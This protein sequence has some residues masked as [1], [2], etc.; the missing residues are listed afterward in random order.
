MCVVRRKDK[1]D[2]KIGVGIKFQNLA[3]GKNTHMVRVV[4]EKGS[5]LPKHTHPE[6]QTGILLEG[7]MDLYINGKT[8]RVKKGDSWSTES[9]VVHG[10]K[11]I[12]KCEVIEVFSPVR[13]DYL[14]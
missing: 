9:G 7:I 10:V 8:Y 5:S 11:V 3:V 13:E 12:E 6:E 14:Q 4:L 2:R 1:W